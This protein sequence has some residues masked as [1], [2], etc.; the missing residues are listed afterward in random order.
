MRPKPLPASVS[1]PR[2]IP[3]LPQRCSPSYSQ[4]PE[5]DDSA[6][7]AIDHMTSE[8]GIRPARDESIPRD[9]PGLTWVPYALRPLSL[10]AL[11]VLNVAL[12][13]TVIAIHAKSVTSLGLVTDDGS[14]SIVFAWRFA[15]TLITV[16]YV[17]FWMI[18][19]DNINRTEA[20]ARLSKFHDSSAPATVL[21]APGPWWSALADSFARQKNDRR[22][23]LVLF[24]AVVGYVLG[25]LILSPFPAAL[26]I[27]RDVIR[28]DKVEFLQ[29]RIDQ[30]SSLQPALDTSTFFR[31]IANIMQNVTTSA[32]ISE[33]YTVVPFWP[34]GLE[35]PLGAQLSDASQ[36]WRANGLVLQTELS[37]ESMNLIRGPNPQEFKYGDHDPS[38]TDALLYT[39]VLSSRSGCEYGFASAS[40][41]RANDPRVNDPPA[42]AS[43]WS[44][45]L[46]TFMP[47]V[48]GSHLVSFL[49]D[50]DGS[51]SDEN[52]F[53]NFTQACGTGYV[54]V[55]FTK[56]EDKAFTATGQLCSSQF[57]AA[58]VSIDA[59]LNDG[60]SLITFDETEYRKIRRPVMDSMI[61][62]TGFQSSFLQAKWSSHL[63]RGTSAEDSFFGGPASL[64]AALYDFRIT[65][66]MADMAIGNKAS[67]IHQRAFG[68]TLQSSLKDVSTL[69]TVPGEIITRQ[70]RV[71]VVQPVAIILEVGL[72]LHLF[73]LT[74]ILLRGQQ[75]QR[76][77]G[78]SR[79]SV[80]TN[81][82]TALVS[83]HQD[84]QTVFRKLFSV[85]SID[86]PAALDG[87]KFTLHNGVLKVS[88]VIPTESSPHPQFTKPSTRL[89]PSQYVP[90]ILSIRLV[91]VLCSFIAAILIAIAVLYWYSL[92]HGL[93]QKVFVYQTRIKIADNTLGTLAPYSVIPTLIAVAISLWWGAIESLFRTVQPYI[94][95]AKGTTS[96][97][98][99]TGVSYQSSYLFWA[100]FRALHRKHWLLTLI[101]LGTFATQICK[102]A[103]IPRFSC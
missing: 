39:L 60:V 67:I 71:V 9:T 22:P 78:L 32:W 90:R 3:P 83:S 4:V 68:E 45:R 94:T 80:F 88:R 28:T 61:N 15:P 18:L 34:S 36:T 10:L 72:I 95:M 50:N 57:F 73:F 103:T 87:S 12:L 35:R 24:S 46:G 44:G 25:F 14:A 99:G 62:V 8:T 65:D 20:F 55:S 48:L 102:Y 23:S 43:H 16:I 101:C 2:S 76:S 89:G 64:L 1:L 52:W 13:A 30:Q 53:M 21:R 69:T 66:M 75:R 37:C 33:K 97:H 92:D 100:A 70:R 54:I 17:V 79:D 51:V 26:L 96:A 31:T 29:P 7:A 5:H 27:S 38:P 81:T 6:P 40:W 58:N 86:L 63:R 93:H 91:S 19:V 49:S 98:R 56:S 42:P 82:I 47:Q 84:T 85:L 59:V 74:I 77:L 11:F 41:S